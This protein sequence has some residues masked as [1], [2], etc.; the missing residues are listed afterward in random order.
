MTI[1]KRFALLG[2]ALVAALVG[3]A[4]AQDESSASLR[5]RLSKLEARAVSQDEKIRTL[6]ARLA[7]YESGAAISSEIETLINGLVD[8]APNAMA[9]KSK[10]VDFG[11]QIRIRG[12]FRSVKNYGAGV[13]DDVDFVLQRTRLHADF[14]IVD[15]VRAFV[16]L[17]DSR[18]WG[19]EGSP[20]GD[21]EGVDIHQAYL[22]YEKV[23]GH[24]WT[25]RVG[26][27]EL[28]YGDQR[29]VSP[30]DWHPVGRSFDGV[31]TWWKGE[32]FQLDVFAMNVV[33][34]SLATGGEA[35]D[36]HYFAGAYFHYTGI[37]AHELD[38]YLFYR[39]FDTG[40]F[41]G[42]N[43]LMGD[44]DDVTIG[45]RF[46]GKTDGFDYSAEIVYQTGDRADDDVNAYAWAAV[47]GYTFD[48]EWKF[49]IGAEWTFASG[50][51]DPTDGD[52]ET[53][54]PLFPFGHSYQGYLDLFAWRN[55][56]DIVL[57]VS[58]K[59]T[60]ELWLEVAFHGFILDEDSDAWYG[61]AGTAIR[62]VGGGVGNEIGYELDI[63]AKYQLD[64]ATALWFGYSH[65]FAGDYVEDTGDSPDTDWIFFQMTVNF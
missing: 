53:F 19:E 51:E 4:R 10:A 11:G 57:K 38:V 54:D 56:H 65:F 14:R 43:G 52:Y 18:N 3:S 22:D 59:P 40:T 35:G 26:R 63:H 36:D 44:L 23:F 1:T 42:E 60:E 48:S 2:L 31:R 20:N 41:V 50:D 17:Q 9:P 33:E 49:R 45:I 5:E 39:G 15:N 30:L 6:E 64:A 28:Q 34:A 21:L 37:E 47:L 58:A 29:L 16:Q 27:Q 61:A 12:E 25:F 62:R 32:T 46:K 55:G 24:D 7:D 13:D 8:D